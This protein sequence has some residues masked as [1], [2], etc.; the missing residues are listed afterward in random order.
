[1]AARTKWRRKLAVGDHRFLWYVAEDEDGMGRV[2][3]LFSP[4]KTVALKYWLGRWRGYPGISILVISV[5]GVN[6]EVVDVPDWERRS[7]VT[8]RFVRDVAEWMLGQIENVETGQSTPV[9]QASRR[10]RRREGGH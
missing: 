8:P 3:H 9:R 5:R 6:R 7:V 4:D 2:L 1:M 10:A